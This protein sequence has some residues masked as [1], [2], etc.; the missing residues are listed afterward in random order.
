[1]CSLPKMQ[2][3]SECQ[4][5]SLIYNWTYTNVGHWFKVGPIQMLAID[6]QLDINILYFARW[7]TVWFWCCIIHK[8]TSK[9]FPEYIEYYKSC[10]LQNRKILP[11]AIITAT[12]IQSNTFSIISHHRNKHKQKSKAWWQKY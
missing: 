11:I 10:K 5:S 2:Q 1:M 4:V 9:P 3:R 6:L 12:F 8:Y 7:F